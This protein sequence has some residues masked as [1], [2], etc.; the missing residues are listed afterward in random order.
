M[1][2]GWPGTRGGRRPSPGG[3]QPR[4]SL[5]PAGEELCL[6][7]LP[8]QAACQAH[9][10]AGTGMPGQRWDGH[11]SRAARGSWARGCSERAPG[12]A[13]A[14]TEPPTSQKHP[15]EQ[16]PLPGSAARWA[17]RGAQ[18][19]IPGATSWSSHTAT[20][21]VPATPVPSLP[22]WGHPPAAALKPRELPSQKFNPKQGPRRCLKTKG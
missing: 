10:G 6:S 13:A 7:V 4:L 11:G 15:E 18:T 16:L 19:A 20:R 21:C 8:V 17:C 2:P 14:R 12:D 1:C 3:N 22:A 9:P 5:V